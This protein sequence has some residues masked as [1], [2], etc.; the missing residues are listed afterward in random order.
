VHCKTE[1][2]PFSQSE[3]R[4][5]DYA[6]TAQF[7]YIPGEDDSYWHAGVAIEY[8]ENFQRDKLGSYFF[9]N[10]NTLTVGPNGQAGV[11]V[12]NVDVGLSDTF[13]GTLTIEPRIRNLI[14]EPSVYFGLDHWLAGAYFWIKL[15]I[16]HTRWSLDCCETDSNLGGLFFGSLSEMQNG[17]FTQVPTSG[18]NQIQQAFSG[19]TTWGD[20]TMPLQACKIICC[21]NTKNGV[22]DIPFHAGWTFLSR[23][24]GY[25]GV[26]FR[27]VVPTGKINEHSH[28][29]FDARVGYDR[30]QAGA[31]INAALTFDYSEKTSINLFIDAFATHIFK[32]TECRCFDLKE[33]GCLSRYLLMKEADQNGLATGH[34]ANFVDI[35]TACAK[36]QFDW[37]VD[38]LVFLNITHN[39]W[40]I[41]LGYE[42]KAR[43]REK[44]DCECPFTICNSSRHDPCDSCCFNEPNTIGTKQYGIKGTTLVEATGTPI[45]TQSKSTMS[46]ASATDPSPVFINAT[47]FDS[48]ID[49]NS[50]A[51]P[52]AVS[53]KVWGNINYMW[54]EYSVSIF[55]ALGGEVEF[56]NKNKA[57]TLWG[58]WGKTGLAYN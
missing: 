9:P 57:A 7:Q 10:T 3:N 11:D 33:N 31:G 4:A 6:G 27:G 54:E 2:L 5:R 26:Y 56:G 12:R 37:N 41:D 1:F 32:R 24:L 39:M 15:P 19:T 55:A 53:N 17:V 23:Q 22:A 18:T 34:L 13:L 46:T 14:I 29:I 49:L 43:D 35:F 47:N 51:Y 20:K 48:L 30:W 45:S 8:N 52:R 38:G 16:V 42:I 36:S 40:G 44:F 25:L 50:A 21:K 28:T 58:I